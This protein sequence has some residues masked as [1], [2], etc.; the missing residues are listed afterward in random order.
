MP[1]QRHKRQGSR[2]WWHGLALAGVCG[3]ALQLQQA[4]LHAQW[5]YISV[6][7][8][9]VLLLLGLS[10]TAAGLWR[11]LALPLLAGACWGWS[12]W[13]AVQRLPTLPAALQG[14]DFDVQGVVTSMPQRSAQAVRFVMSV[15]EIRLVPKDGAPELPADFAPP[16]RLSLS[17]YP[18]R[19]A[20]GDSAQQMVQRP[21]VQPGQRWR[22]R[23]RLKTPHGQ[24]NPAGFDHELWMWERGLRVSGYVRIT[25]DGPVPELLASAQGHALQR[26]RHTVRDSL[27][28]RGQDWP[29]LQAV[30]GVLAA[31]VTGDQAAIPPED[32]DVFR[33]TGVAHLMSI[34]GLHIT[35]LVWLMRAWALRV[36]RWSLGTWPGLAHRPWVLRWPIQHLA[37]LLA[38]CT[39]LAYALFSG[40]GV[41]AQR[42]VIMLGMAMLLQHTGK[43]W[44]WSLVWL[45]CALG[46][47]M[48]D[49]W[50][51][52]QPG[53]WLS[54]VAVGV[55]LSRGRAL[56]D[57]PHVAPQGH[58]GA[59]ETGWRRRAH[60][61]GV[62]AAVLLREQSVIMLALAPLSVLFFGQWSLVGLL[63]N[64]LA[65]AWVSYGVTPL[66]LLGVLVPGVWE[67]SA[68]LMWPLWQ[69]L[70]TL[71]TWP[72]A[73][74]QWP[75][76]PWPV[77]AMALCG[78]WLW[79]RPWAMA[80]RMAGL[81][82]L[83]PLLL[84]QPSRPAAG[85]FD[86]WAPDVGQGNAVLVR[87]R[88]STLLY[89]TGPRYSDYSDAGERVLGP[90]LDR[91]REPLTDLVLSHSD[92]DHTGG[93]QAV[94]MRYPDVTL[95][96]SMTVPEDLSR[97]RVL[98]T[99]EQGRRWSRDGVQFEFLH[100]P[101]NYTP[102]RTATNAGSCVLRISNGR[103][104][105]LL[106][107]DIEAAQEAQLLEQGHLTPVDVLLVP[108]HG[109]KTSSSEAFLQ[110]LR[111]RWSWVQAGHMNRYG[112]P[113]GAV[114]ERYAVLGLPVVRTDQC[115]ALH[116]RSDQAE[117]TVCWRQQARR[118][119]HDTPP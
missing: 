70:H 57:A 92:T 9:S 101:P 10:K 36:W 43:L 99:C 20:W 23:V 63:A 7:G 111:P 72:S 5:I 105:V 107:A 28:A 78:V 61:I 37:A 71:A 56:A 35:M 86:V 8:L 4:Q 11:W 84:W 52:L 82:L 75:I 114:M 80:L 90:W 112:H 67:L 50:A 21:D 14:R 29:Q 117:R 2:A 93:V 91:S 48:F 60:Q 38:W 62:S 77:A 19:G 3:V 102:V 32:W 79:M 53:F 96:S 68:W 109:S 87:T 18:S 41:P 26:W 108:H 30:Y 81:P 15:D 74:V 106:V 98:R 73:V 58:Q 85:E 118:Y 119:W 66:A 39:G 17:W 65:I 51:L 59:P 104:S 88:G 69:A 83:M 6:L 110:A 24:L 103:R 31:L 94:L 54:F 46:V 115:G 89:D 13:L 12:G 40:W 100:P 47:L 45:W 64:L 113:A 95:W 44:P 25:R 116:W 16:E 49:P 22:M 33:V 76:P 97:A 55:L 42:T 34:S 27:L 1:E